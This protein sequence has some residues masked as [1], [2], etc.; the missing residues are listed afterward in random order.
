MPIASLDVAGE[1]LTGLGSHHARVKL[2]S[3]KALRELS[4]R[5]PELVYPHFDIFAGLLGHGNNILKW[6]AMLT[7]ANL[8]SVDRE[9]KLDR[10]LD[11]YLAPIAGPVM[12]TAANAMKGAALIAQAKPHL[13]ERIAK[14]IL[15]VERANYASG[16]CRNVAIGHALKT[17]GTL[18]DSRRLRA[19]ARRQLDNP[20]R[21]TANKARGLLSAFVR[22]APR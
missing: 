1:L 22:Q 5:E 3:S 20:R 6:N 12:I 10:L 2:G 17:L 11:V 21:A 8:A 9:G 13:A 16:E 14:A 18:G 15:R 7:L 19:F 4:R